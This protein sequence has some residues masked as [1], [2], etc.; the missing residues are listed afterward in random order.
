MVHVAEI[1]RWDDLIPFRLVWRELWG[2]TPRVSFF[3]SF[4]WFS[5]A[6]K[7]FGDRQ[8]F[9]VLVI[10]SGDKVVGLLPLVLRRESSRLGAFH[11]LTYPLDS[12]GDFFG[13]IGPHPTAT[14]LAGLRYL[15]ESRRDWDVLDLRWVDQDRCDHLRTPMA[16]KQVGFTPLAQIWDRSAVIDGRIGWAEYWATRSSKF[17]NNLRRAEKRVLIRGR[18]ELVRYRPAGAARGE[19][20]PRWDLFDACV[21]LASRSWQGH[22]DQGKTLSHESV[23]GFLREVHESAAKL[24]CL[25]LNLLTVDGQPI[26]FAYNYVCG[27]RVFGLRTGYDPGWADASPGNVLKLWMIRDSFERGD[28][29]FDLGPGNLSSKQPWATDFVDSYRYTYFSPWSPRAQLLRWKRWWDSRLLSTEQRLARCS[30]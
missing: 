26:A 2:K 4:E 27:G 25:D 18:A 29:E 1:T 30:A 16:M 24:G 19:D 28:E 23:Y 14:L 9:R 7:H 15:A 3:Q 17:R 5:A 22:Q 21:D 11:V 6:W 10:S 20:D 12:W 8:S 13:P